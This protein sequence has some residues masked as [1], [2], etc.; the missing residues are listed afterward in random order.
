MFLIF[1]QVL[2]KKTLCS[3]S[4]KTV[5]KQ[6]KKSEG[7]DLLVVSIN[8]CCKV[9]EELS[10]NKIV[11]LVS[12]QWLFTRP[13]NIAKLFH[14]ISLTNY[15]CQLNNLI[16]YLRRNYVSR[17]WPFKRFKSKLKSTKLKSQAYSNDHKLIKQRRK[18]VKTFLVSSG[19][20]VRIMES[21][22][23][24]ERRFAGWLSK[25]LPKD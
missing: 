7:D 11:I 9:E 10:I 16:I 8:N 4:M 21:L 14:G 1:F 23:C 6:F 12:L 20:S 18:A 22:L 19:G 17:G 3:I 25:N 13:I 2:T 24:V 15:N 5:C